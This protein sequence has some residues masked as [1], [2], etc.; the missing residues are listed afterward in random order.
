MT[1][2]NELDRYGNHRDFIVN[3]VKLRGYT[4]GAEIGLGSAKLFRRWLQVIP[5]IHMIGVDIGEKAHWVEAQKLVEDDYPDRATYYQAPSVKAAKYVPDDS[6]DFVFI[7]AGHAYGAVKA[8]IAAWSPKVKRG[9]EILG[10][11]FH[12][13]FPGVIKAVKEEFPSEFV[14]LDHYIWK[15]QK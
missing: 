11:D 14:L 7:D 3:Y 12:K 4:R 10:H 2:P 5:E 6:L 8:D 1:N 15:V 13:K 9:G